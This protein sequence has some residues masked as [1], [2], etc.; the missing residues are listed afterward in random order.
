[1]ANLIMNDIGDVN[2][3]HG[4]SFNNNSSAT[5]SRP[6]RRSLYTDKQRRILRQAFNID[7]YPSQETLDQ[8]VNELSLPLAR[9]SNWFHNARMR[10]KNMVRSSTSPIINFTSSPLNNN[11]N[12]VNEQSEEEDEYVDNNNNP[13]NEDQDDD[14]DDEY[15]NM[16][17][18]RPTIVP[19]GR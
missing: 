5:Q 17:S 6:K 2:N 4:N 14:D 19:L 10:A 18:S 16:D 3:S 15:G 12:V 9:I 11:D 8:L 13:N 7:P 1:M